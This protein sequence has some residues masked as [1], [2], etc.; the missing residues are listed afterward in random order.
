MLDRAALPE[1]ARGRDRVRRRRTALRRSLR[2]GRPERGDTGRAKTAI[3]SLLCLRSWFGPSAGLPGTSNSVALEVVDHRWVMRPVGVPGAAVDDGDK[4]V[5][6]SRVTPSLA[7]PSTAGPPHAT[8]RLLGAG[9]SGSPPTGR[10]FVAFA[11][12]TPWMADRIRSGTAIRC[13]SSGFATSSRAALVDE[14]VLV[15]QQPRVG[16]RRPG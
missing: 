14:R 15:E 5:P 11:R 6:S 3:N 2:Q 16:D 9:G 8:Q 1:P 12:V 4:V 10:Q 7:A 13:S